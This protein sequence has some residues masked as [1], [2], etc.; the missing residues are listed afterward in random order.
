VKRPRFFNDKN[1]IYL[2]LNHKK[3]SDEASSLQKAFKHGFLTFLL[4]TIPACQNPKNLTENPDPI[5]IRIRSE[6]L[7]KSGHSLLGISTPYEIYLLRED[8]KTL[9]VLVQRLPP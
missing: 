2:F 4:K 9:K 1:A 6:T 8:K 3:A 5:W 7:H